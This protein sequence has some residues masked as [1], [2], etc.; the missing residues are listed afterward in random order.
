[1][2]RMNSIWLMFGLFSDQYTVW[3]SHTLVSSSFCKY[4]PMFNWQVPKF[5]ING[6]VVVNRNLGLESLIKLIFT[7]LKSLQ[8]PAEIIA[9][10]N[11]GPLT[12]EQK[13][14]KLLLLQIQ[15]I[16]IFLLQ[17]YPESDAIF[18]QIAEDCHIF[19]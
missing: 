1:M 10:P 3:H 17:T 9:L 16:G 8:N 4:E 13:L 18:E 2:P 15:W 19:V 12:F 5:L 6:V 11:L 14:L 7:S